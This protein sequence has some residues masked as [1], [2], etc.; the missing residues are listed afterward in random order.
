MNVS[1]TGV[2]VSKLPHL[3]AAKNRDLL[4]LV[5]SG[6]IDARNE[7]IRGNLT[8]VLSVVNRF[9][10]EGYDDD[11]FQVGCIGLIKAIDNFDL[12]RN[13]A[14]STYAVPMIIGE[15]RRHCRDNIPAV[16]VPRSIR[17]MAY[18][19]LKLADKLGREPTV[20]EISEELNIPTEEIA[21]AL[22]S[23]QRPISIYEPVAKKGDDKPQLV[24]D[25][26]ADST[27]TE[28]N[29]ANKL[30]VEYAM[31]KLTDRERLIMKLRESDMKQTEV[32]RE[33]G[34]SQTQISRLENQA[35]NKIKN[36]L[37]EVC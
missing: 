8:L 14:F 30:D 10:V 31:D 19:C 34:V 15:I 17:D 28:D 3:T 27:E 26:I 16:R 5:A 21:L 33:I 24:E 36:Q 18:K 1:I 25:V 11:L 32:A 35:I 7:L 20:K 12:S 13:C 29:W 37:R 9:H 4:E 23:T 6:N 2:N 22:C